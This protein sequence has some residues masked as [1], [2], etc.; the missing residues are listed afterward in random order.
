MLAAECASRLLKITRLLKM[1][2]NSFIRHLVVSASAAA[3]TVAS[4]GSAMAATINSITFD[5]GG[6]RDAAPAYSYNQGGIKLDVTASSTA[7]N[8]SGAKV[9]RRTTGLGVDNSTNDNGP[10]DGYAGLDT[11]HLRFSSAVELSSALFTLIIDEDKT[12]TNNNEIV[13]GGGSLFS[14]A[15]PDNGNGQSLVNSFTSNGGGLEFQF[16]AT[17]NSDNYR[18]K[19]VEVFNYADGT[20]VPEPMTVVATIIGGGAVLKMRKKLTGDADSTPA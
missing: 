20:S 9:T 12:T 15:L 19:R 18:L 16:S 6:S 7:P 2:Y 10:I 8:S 14:G 5:L 17:N 3:I 13:I 4:A 11:L 1:S